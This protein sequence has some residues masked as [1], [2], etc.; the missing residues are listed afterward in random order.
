MGLPYTFNNEVITDAKINGDLQYLDQQYFRQTVGFDSGMTGYALNAGTPVAAATTIFKVHLKARS[1][2]TIDRISFSGKYLASYS[3][4]P[5]IR[6]AYS[7]D[8]SSWTNISS[9][10]HAATYNVGT[11]VGNVT[12]LSNANIYLRI[13]TETNACNVVLLS[14]QIQYFTSDGAQNVC[15]GMLMATPDH[16]TAEYAEYIGYNSGSPGRRC[17]IDVLPPT[18]KT[19]V[20]LSAYGISQQNSDANSTSHTAQLEYSTNDGGAWSNFSEYSTIT[21]TYNSG[22]RF[23]HAAYGMSTGLS[24][25]KA[26]VSV[27]ATTTS[28]FTSHT[29]NSSLWVMAFYE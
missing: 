25:S 15:E 12:G 6:L 2:Q 4:N 11:L 26:R 7:T 28:G 19:I 17:F 16:N 23:V 22:T 20:S 8:N 3:S 10:T 5:T 14:A 18:G 9:G 27:T 29:Y 21:G 13:A 1:G 24:L